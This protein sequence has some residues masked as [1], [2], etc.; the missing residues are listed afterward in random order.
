[1]EML[2]DWLAL[3][4]LPFAAQAGVHKALSATLSC[5]TLLG[6]VAEASALFPRP[7]PPPPPPPD[8][9]AVEDGE[10]GESKGETPVEADA[11]RQSQS[12]PAPSP[13]PMAMEVEVSLPPMPPSNVI[14]PACTLALAR[15][16][17]RSSSHLCTLHRFSQKL[18]TFPTLWLV[19]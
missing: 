13:P 4:M 15:R 14:S 10:G 18:R 17:P 5:P 16:L 1:M 9:P 6:A 11:H 12:P 3:A 19:R 2:V 8:P 7:P